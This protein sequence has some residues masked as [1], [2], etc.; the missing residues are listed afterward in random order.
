MPLV[1]RQVNQGNLFVQ[2]SEPQTWNDG[3]LWV[4]LGESPPL[5]KVNDNGTANMVQ[6]TISEIV[7]FG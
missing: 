7:G 1:T 5:L 2:D 4:D 6:R 3:D